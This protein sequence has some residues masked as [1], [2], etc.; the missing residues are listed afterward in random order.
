MRE[1]YAILALEDR[2]GRKRLLPVWHR[3]DARE[4]TRQSAILA[5]YKGISTDLGLEEV[6]QQ[7]IGRISAPAA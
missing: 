5:T 4:V 1:V 2:D 3:V 7:I 6:A